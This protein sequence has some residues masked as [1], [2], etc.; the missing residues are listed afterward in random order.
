MKSRDFEILYMIRLVADPSHT[1]YS[2][3]IDDH[4]SLH[5]II[6]INYYCAEIRMISYKAQVLILLQN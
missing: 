4:S 3:L 5:I 6:I 2:V 1:M